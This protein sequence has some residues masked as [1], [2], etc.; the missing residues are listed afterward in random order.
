MP[1]NRRLPLIVSFDAE[2]T[3]ATHDFSIAVWQE[4]VPAL[5]AESRGMEVGDAKKVVFA[6][7]MRVGMQRKEWFEIDYWFERFG[8]GPSAPII[9][10]H[11]HRI[12]FYPEVVPVLER[13]QAECRLV[14]ASSTPY[15]F[16]E[17]LLRDVAGYF[18]R[19]FSATSEFGAVKDPSFF[20]WMC[21]EL[22]VEPCDIVHVGDSWK[23]DYLGALEAGMVSY[24]LD[25]SDLASAHLHDLNGL[26]AAL[27]DGAGPS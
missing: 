24:Y 4:V 19:M 16:L 21:S 12:E 25:R 11:R 13:L 22:R 10:A 1:V 20:R 3:L 5:Y 9:E 17:P 7:Y 27:G 6:E 8:L 18:T 26:V 14:V 2:G 15:E 23:K